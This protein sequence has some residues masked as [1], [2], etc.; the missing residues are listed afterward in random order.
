MAAGRKTKDAREGGF[1]WN[2]FYKYLAGPATTDNAIEGVTPEARAAWER[3]L[4]ARK[5][6]SRRQRERKRAE[7]EGRRGA[8]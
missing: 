7:R 3:D 1:L 6:W 4:A 8:A 2:A 5:E